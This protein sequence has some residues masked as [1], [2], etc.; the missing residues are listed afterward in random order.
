[1]DLLAGL[2]LSNSNMT[3]FDW[4]DHEN[5]TF[6]ANSWVRAGEKEV[7]ISGSLA[8]KV[9]L[10]SDGVDFQENSFKISSNYRDYTGTTRVKVDTLTHSTADLGRYTPS[11]I[12]FKL[13]GKD[14][15]DLLKL[16]NCPYV[17]DCTVVENSNLP[18]GLPAMGNVSD[19]V[20]GMM[21]TPATTGVTIQSVSYTKTAG[22]VLKF[23]VNP[24]ITTY[25]TKSGF[26]K[27]LGLAAN[28]VILANPMKLNTIQ[29][30]P[31]TT[32]SWQMLQASN[33]RVKT[34]GAY[35]GQ[36]LVPQI[37]GNQ[38]DLE[39]GK[40]TIRLMPIQETVFKASGGAASTYFDAMNVN[41]TYAKI[42]KDLFTDVNN[43]TTIVNGSDV[44]VFFTSA[45]AN[46]IASF[47]PGTDV[48]CR[49]NWI[50]TFVEERLDIMLRGTNLSASTQLGTN[51]KL[52]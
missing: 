27:D 4:F 36:D 31:G 39:N 37:E 50:K 15:S 18:G 40:P 20:L 17:I 6:T 43:L 1:V 21:S 45:T 25:S 44:R 46:A 28:S 11:E 29:D 13:H 10:F 41:A 52:R 8:N 51:E 26:T 49:V 19:D 34:H 14:V 23:T 12:I 30:G 38:N 9:K 16:K 7:A 48:S 42:P 22:I 33:D 3:Y 24:I 35:T 32:W 47:C 2:M 5:I